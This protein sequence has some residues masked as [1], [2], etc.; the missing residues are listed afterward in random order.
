MHQ[1]MRHNG[2]VASVSV[3]LFERE[4]VAQL[5]WLAGGQYAW[6]MAVGAQLSY[7]NVHV[8]VNVDGMSA[9]QLVCLQTN[10]ASGLTT[11]I[12]QTD[13]HATHQ[14]TVTPLFDVSYIHENR[15]F[16]CTCFF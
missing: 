16:F 3:L 4:R 13:T 12:Q 9:C 5:L 6:E 14:S 2:Y 15:K 1:Q 7:A 10:V 11:T 8:Y